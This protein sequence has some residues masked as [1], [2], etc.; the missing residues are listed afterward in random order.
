MNMS[1]LVHRGKTDNLAK[2]DTKG[3]ERHETNPGNH[4]CKKTVTNRKQN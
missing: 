4:S 3:N 1:K 2:T